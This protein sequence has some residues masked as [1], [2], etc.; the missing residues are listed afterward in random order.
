MLHVGG[1]AQTVLPETD[2]MQMLG[3]KD[4]GSTKGGDWIVQRF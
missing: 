4:K 1:K 2:V 3:V